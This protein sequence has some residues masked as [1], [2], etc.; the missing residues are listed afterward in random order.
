MS[1]KEIK[2]IPRVELDGLLLGLRNYTTIHAF[3]GYNDKD[4]SEMAKTK[5]EVNRQYRESMNLKESF[6]IKA[7]YKK[8]VIHTSLRDALR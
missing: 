8:R 7:G 2:Q 3:D 1:W 5:P 4:I 6:E